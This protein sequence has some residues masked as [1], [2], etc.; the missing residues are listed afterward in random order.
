M[1]DTTSGSALGCQ[2]AHAALRAAEEH[3][4]PLSVLVDIVAH[5]GQCSHGAAYQAVQKHLFRRGGIAVSGKRRGRGFDKD[6]QVYRIWTPA[7]AGAA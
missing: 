3:G 5:V 6:S 4:L 2:V 7:K 1:I